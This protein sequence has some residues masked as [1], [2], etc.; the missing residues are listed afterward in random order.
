[1]GNPMI[2]IDP[3]IMQQKTK[4]KM[5]QYATEN[6]VNEKIKVEDE[7]ILDRFK[8]QCE[9]NFMKS[10]DENNCIETASCQS[11]KQ[12]RKRNEEND[13]KVEEVEI[14]SPNH[15]EYARLE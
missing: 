10:N 3:D 5:S 7:N 11:Q 1:M 6:I 13:V 15:V 2:T 9:T 14:G 8:D 12:K 4:S